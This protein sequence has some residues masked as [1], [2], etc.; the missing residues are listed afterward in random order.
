MDILHLFAADLGDHRHG[1]MTRVYLLHHRGKIVDCDPD[2]AVFA[3]R[4]FHFVP[5]GPEE[6]RRVILVS[7][8][9]RAKPLA[10]LRE[11]VGI[12][13]IEPLSHL[14]DPQSGANRKP[15]R[16]SRIE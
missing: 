13:P 2:R 12:T 6:Q 15:E 11:S 14:A 9:R 4:I 3:L 7:D 1:R 10:L 5:D 8:H 16:L